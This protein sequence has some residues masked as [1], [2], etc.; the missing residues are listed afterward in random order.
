ML[1]LVVPIY[2]EA[3]NVENLLNNI[4]KNINIPMEILFIYDMDWDNTLPVIKSISKNYNSEIKLIKNKYSKGVLNAIKTGFEEAKNKAILVIM[5]DLSDDL[6]IVNGMYDMI[7]NQGYD[8]VCGSRY[9]RG[10]KQIGGPIIKKTISK[11]AGLSLHFLT[12][13]PTHDITNSFK[14][15]NKDFLKRINIESTG[16]FEIGMEITVKAFV[17]GAKIGEIPS[18]WTDRVKGKSRFKLLKWLPKY[19]KWYFYAFKKFF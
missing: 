10:G 16:G 15:Y 18:V 7:S 13:I 3:E 19:L 5:A 17:M 8:I 4:H 12:G 6:S 11:L 9:A 14:M 1:S 2:N